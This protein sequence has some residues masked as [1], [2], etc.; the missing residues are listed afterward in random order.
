MAK[1]FFVPAYFLAALSIIT[2]APHEGHPFNKKY[3]MNDYFLGGAI[4]IQTPFEGLEY[5]IIDT[6]ITI[7]T[8]QAVWL[9]KYLQG[10]NFPTEERRK[11][12]TVA[13]KL[14]TQDGENII[15]APMPPATDFNK[16]DTKRVIDTLP[17]VIVNRAGN[18]I[19]IY[20]FNGMQGNKLVFNITEFENLM[21]TKEW[22]Y[23]MP[24]DRTLGWVFGLQIDTITA[25]FAGL[26]YNNGK[27][28]LLSHAKRCQFCKPGPFNMYLS[29][30]SGA[31][32]YFSSVN[33]LVF[34][35]NPNNPTKEHAFKDPRFQ[36]NAFTYLKG[37]NVI[38]VSGLNVD[39]LDTIRKIICQS[40]IVDFNC[41]ALAA[42]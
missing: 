15:L 13:E 21:T 16:A 5:K 38:R 14:R 7:P 32:Y 42:Q 35:T 36:G 22:Y 23:H 2:A 1:K 26:G 25:D 17:Y 3:V 10:G 40:K 41:A 30:S 27:T 33:E 12:G 28:D 37:N 8:N 18:F 20:V 9:V 39:D 29:W 24:A 31:H 34:A 6:N 11:K 19:T 4:A